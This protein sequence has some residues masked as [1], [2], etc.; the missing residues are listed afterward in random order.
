[1][2]FN[3]GLG[4]KRA[5]NGSEIEENRETPHIDCVLNPKVF[6]KNLAVVII[7]YNMLILVQDFM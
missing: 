3:R 2:L 4:K 6:Q 7:Y 5:T 1:M